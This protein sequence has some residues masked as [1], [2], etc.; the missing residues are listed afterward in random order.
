[1][2]DIFLKLLNMSI[3]AGWL[4][5]VVLCVR[6]LFRK[7]PKWVSCVL[8][9]VVAV[10]LLVPFSVESAFSLQPSAEPIKTS[11]IVE[12]EVL[13]YIP[14]IDSNLSIV[15]NTVNPMLAETFFY[16]ASESAAPLQV[17]TGIAGGVWLC[18]MI[19]LLLFAMGSMVRLLFLVRE[20]VPYRDSVFICDEVKS[21]FIL[22]I[23]KPRIYLSSALSEKEMNFCVAHEKAHLVRKDHLWKPLGYLI[24]CVYWFNPLC[25][26]AYKFLCKDIELACDEKVIKSMSFADKKE[27]SRV[28]LSCAT[29]RRLVS[30]CPLAFGEVGVKERVKSVLRYKKPAFWVTTAAVVVCVIV[31]ACFLTNPSKEYQIRITIPAGSTVA[32]CY[33]EEEISSKG[34]VLK[35]E[36][37]DGLGDTEAILLPVE[38]R[39]ENTYEPAYM[40]PGMPVKMDVEKGAWYKIG[41]NVQNP[42]A[43]DKDVYVSVKNVEVRIAEKDEAESENDSYGN[44]IAGLQDQDAYAFLVLDDAHNVMLTSDLIYDAG[45]ETQA[46]VSCDVYYAVD[47]TA[48]KL[49]SIMSD[50]TAYPIT[51]TI[52][53]IFVASGHKIEKYTVSKDGALSLEKGVYEQFDEAGNAAYISRTG[54]QERVSDEREYQEM[55][56]EYAQSQI[57][58]FS[59]GAEGSVN[60][61]QEKEAALDV[62][63]QNVDAQTP[64]IDEEGVYDELVRVVSSVGL[65]NAFPWNNTVNLKENADALIQM[66][67]DETGRFEIYGIMSEK[68]GTYGLLLNDWIGGQENWNFAYVPWM[69]SGAPSGQPILESD[70]KGAYIFA[71]IY[72]YED[73]VAHW[74][75]CLLDCGYDTGH[76][77]LLSQEEYAKKYGEKKEDTEKPGEEIEIP[78]EDADNPVA[79]SAMLEAS[80]ITSIV[81]INGNTGDRKTLTAEDIY[82][83]QEL[84]KLYRQLDFTAECEEN[85]RIGYQYCMKLQDADGNT[86]QSVTPYKDGLTVDRVFYR[87]EN[88]GEGAAASL[89][90][91]EYLEYLF[92]PE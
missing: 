79:E 66:A 76:M 5:L 25:W 10:R 52:D 16:H 59:Y 36:N 70:G 90:L 53:G 29:Q 18:G 83:Y 82:P 89:R 23:I 31:A 61:Y 48:K 85:E 12:G 84:L 13:P 72:E 56:K 28:L 55:A 78:G 11:A 33:S 87:Y 46:A 43:E 8:W 21:P 67:S 19:V 92:H 50:G 26:L 39:E 9:G 62:E 81:V 30:V 51:F 75:E 24:L 77:E 44:I 22:G 15:E 54:K 32:F 42:T 88:I 60:E 58:H 3:S 57:V 68:Y 40:T 27:Y 2:G 45:T 91:M 86:L 49:G 1:M 17:F 35:M 64:A 34:N 20:A 38:V 80:A 73:G 7:M 65:E 47:G 14:S 71:Y 63:T 69:Y 4:I 37:G 74:H 6:F 41:V